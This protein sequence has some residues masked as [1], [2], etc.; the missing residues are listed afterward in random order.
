MKRTTRTRGLLV[1]LAFAP[2]TRAAHA[3]AAAGDPHAHCQEAAPA[4]AAPSASASRVDVEVV[5]AVLLDQ[6]GAEVHFKSDVVGDR[7]VV[8]NFVYTTCT[9]ICPL[10]SAR[11]ARLQERLGDRQGRDVFLVSISVDPNRDTP[12]RLKAYAARHG[13]R[14]GW[15]H[16]TG[17][18]GDVDRV[19]KGLGA[20]TG[21]FVDHAPMI[22]VGDGRTGRWARLNGFPAPDQVL[23]VIDDLLAARRQAA[24]E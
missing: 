17:T 18:K 15:S 11:F 14:A 20:Y 23:A 10:L 13:A 24:M 9:T 22:L 19:L 12:A 6:D 8:M 3:P 4:P 7:L 16:L 2:A 5:N 21:N 1:A